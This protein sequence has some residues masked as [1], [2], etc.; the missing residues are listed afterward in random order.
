MSSCILDNFW[1]V[2]WVVSELV[3]KLV[4]KLVTALGRLNVIQTNKISHLLHIPVLEAL[5]FCMLQSYDLLQFPN[6]SKM[7][8]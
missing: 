7:Q 3:P 4:S 6:F 1:V 2:F 8:S 5:R